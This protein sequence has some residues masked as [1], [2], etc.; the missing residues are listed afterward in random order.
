MARFVVQS[1]LESSIIDRSLLEKVIGQWVISSNVDVEGTVLIVGGGSE[2]TRI[3]RSFGFHRI[4]LSNLR[5]F[6]SEELS[7]LEC[8]GLSTVTADV[9]DMPIPDGSY[10]LVFT[11]AVVHHCRSPHKALLEMLRVSRKHIIIM[12]PNESLLMRALVKLR[13]SFPYEL[14]AVISNRFE[15]GG[16]RNSC[17][18]NYIYRW[19]AR[20]MYQA[21]ASYMPERG[22]D[23]YVRQYWDFNI[24]AEELARRSETRIG[25]ITKII[26]AD[27]FLGGLRCFQA[28]VNRLPWLQSQGNKFFGC[29]TKQDELKPWL[30]NEGDSIVFNRNYPQR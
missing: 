22:F 23:L 24:D 16:V 26:G 19:G 7:Q 28:V 21:T 3:L 1:T 2:D 17:V 4:T 6:T 8:E 25:R 30:E 18:P 9:E 20:D 10:D 5:D 11:H 13:F 14:P 29:I 12:E 27:L 15:S